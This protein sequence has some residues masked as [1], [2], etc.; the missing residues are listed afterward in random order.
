MCS[1]RVTAGRTGTETAARHRLRRGHPAT[2]SQLHQPPVTYTNCY[3]GAMS[4]FSSLGTPSDNPFSPG[5]GGRPRSLVGRKDL[6]DSIGGGLATGPH[7][8]RYT[9]L[10]IGRRGSGKTVVLQEI[11]G[12]AA[13]DGWLVLKLDAVNKG[14]P[15]RISQAVYALE[16]EQSLDLE[17]RSTSKTTGLTVAGFGWTRTVIDKIR[18][19]WD[20]R[21][22]LTALAAHAQENDASVLVTLDEMHSGDRDELR[23]FAA[24]IQHITKKSELPLGF[25]GAGLPS[26]KTT[27][28]ED[29][30][31]T[32]FHR[33]AQFD[34]PA[35]TTTD[36][37]VG[38]RNTITDAGGAIDDDALRYAASHCGSLPYKLQ[39]IG[40]NAWEI[41]DASRN[42][43]DLSVVRLAVEA[44][45]A[46]FLERIS[47][48]AWFAL[49]EQD[50][51]YLE[52]VAS[53]DG[54]ASLRSIAS[55]LQRPAKSLSRS[56][57]RL[58]ASGY[59]TVSND[60][61]VSLT[62]MLPA[63]TISQLLE[64]E[65]LHADFIGGSVP[66]TSTHRTTP[67]CQKYM[68]RAKAHCVR[69]RGHP[70]S[71]ASTQ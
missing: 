49:S 18:P 26:M 6:L 45:E 44:A 46:T 15:E 14:L 21:R 4:G 47:V 36:A 11:E 1:R 59:A 62:E 20:A 31:L 13:Q 66:S 8:E 19:D 39:H 68:P 67:R 54:T 52:V 2:T 25:L 16:T 61:T 27:L 38:L 48:P 56:L 58:V 29:N 34:M 41:A 7:S 69:R 42:R 63:S 22:Q 37:L 12:R 60:R 51:D 57:R 24:D 43:I 70:G 28:L 9:S 30:H 3:T 64:T 5:F 17:D 33:C 32:F 71:C 65:R 10:L 35:L 50:Q 53:S 23:R 55:H 40:H